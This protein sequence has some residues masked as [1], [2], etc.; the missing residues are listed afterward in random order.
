MPSSTS[1]NVTIRIDIDELE[2][3]DKAVQREGTTRTEYMLRWVPEHYG[4]T[5]YGQASKHQA[6]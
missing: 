6:A 1:T 2:R 4:P 3:V 5:L